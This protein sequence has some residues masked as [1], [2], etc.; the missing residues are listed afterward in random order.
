VEHNSPDDF[1]SNLMAGSTSISLQVLQLL[2]SLVPNV[3]PFK[4]GQGTV[5]LSRADTLLPVRLASFITGTE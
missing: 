4:L 5:K 1:H 2:I 3:H